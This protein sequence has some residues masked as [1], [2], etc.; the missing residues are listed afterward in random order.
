MY[1]PASNADGLTQ[2]PAPEVQAEGEAPLFAPQVFLAMAGFACCFLWLYTSNW[3]LAYRLYDRFGTGFTP[4]LKMWVIDPSMGFILGSLVLSHGIGCLLFASLPGGASLGRDALQRGICMLATVVVVLLSVCLPVLE[5]ELLFAAHLL[6]GLFSG[7]PVTRVFLFASRKLL[8]DQRPIALGFGYATALATHLVVVVLGLDCFHPDVHPVA[9][10]LFMAG[11]F[12]C[13]AA[14]AWRIDGLDLPDAVRFMPRHAAFG[15]HV[16]WPLILVT[17]AFYPGL[18][19]PEFSLLVYTEGL[20][21]P[22]IA[23]VAALVSVL[24]ALGLYLRLSKPAVFIVALTLLLMAPGFALMYRYGFE[25]GK[26]A[27][28]GFSHAGLWMFEMTA[29]ILF[30]NAACA[31]RRPMLVA[32]LGYIARM[33]VGVTYM[34]SGVLHIEQR[35]PFGVIYV[36]FNAICIP[37]IPFVFDN[38]RKIATLASHTLYASRPADAMQPATVADAMPPMLDAGQ[39]AMA[40]IATAGGETVQRRGIP[41]DMAMLL[42]ARELEIVALFATGLPTHEIAAQLFIAENTLRNYFSRIYRKLGIQSR[43]QLMALLQQGAVA[44]SAQQE[45]PGVGGAGAHSIR[46]TGGGDP[47][48]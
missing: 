41:L 40:G 1:S 44:T 48:Q 7:W 45:G 10:A 8:P 46:A 27:M 26:Y 42:T 5:G 47:L 15:A 35:I 43:V 17:I 25:W 28:A 16:F 11:V 23:R 6:V 12:A 33:S 29:N 39:D 34:L 36:F 13:A 14:I 4:L 24:V 31:S 30:L 38:L 37:F 20:A 2:Q 3:V 21:I 22:V 32:S 19:V 18:R 9:L